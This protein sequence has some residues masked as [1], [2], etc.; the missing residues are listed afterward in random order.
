M[1]NI[2][3]FKFI[4][5]EMFVFEMIIKY[6]RSI[7]EF[8]DVET[9]ERR[10]DSRDLKKQIYRLL[11]QKMNSVIAFNAWKKKQQM[12]EKTIIYENFIQ[13]KYFD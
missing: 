11:D 13:M 10:I 3:L 4:I 2:F 1:N 9:L 8:R 5:I 7:F 6:I 12:H